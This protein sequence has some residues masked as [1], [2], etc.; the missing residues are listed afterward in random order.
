MQRFIKHSTKFAYFLDISCRIIMDKPG[1]SI[2]EFV[3]MMV[4]ISLSLAGRSPMSFIRSWFNGGLPGGLTGEARKEA[5]QLMTELIE[6]GSKE[7]FLSERPGGSYDIHCHHVR[8]RA[9]G[10]R[11]LAL[12]GL[13]L[14][15]AVRDR[16]KKKLGSV[17]VEHL[18]Y[19]WSD[20][21]GW[22][23]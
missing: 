21:G 17:L 22:L 16:M 9:I 8:T 2:S 4:N 10:K 11:L 12:G 23:P 18:N 20:I 7:D 13:P 15:E 1:L 3:I 14:M 19:A 5:N 6:I